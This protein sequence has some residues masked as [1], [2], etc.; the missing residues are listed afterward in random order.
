MVR[1]CSK[2]LYEAPRAA[3]AFLQASAEKWATAWN[4]KTNRLRTT[5]RF[6]RV[7]LPCPK[8]CSRLYPPVSQSL[9]RSGA[10]RTPP[11]LGPRCADPSGPGHARPRQRGNHRAIPACPAGGQFV[12]VSDGVTTVDP[13]I[14]SLMVTSSCNSRVTDISDISFNSSVGR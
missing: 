2:N 7:F 11:R 5:R 8:L 12:Q 9:T 3:T 4:E 13:P 14:G 1:R 10:R 6:A